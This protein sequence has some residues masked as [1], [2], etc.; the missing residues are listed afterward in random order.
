[1]KYKIGDKVKYDDGEWL[2]YGTVSA[3]YEHSICPLYRVNIE[4]KEKKNGRH[5]IVQFEFELETDHSLTGNEK[6]KRQWISTEIDY[7]KEYYTTHNIEDISK[8]LKRNIEEIEDK[9][10]LIKLGKES[11]EVSEKIEQQATEQEPKV[12]RKRKQKT[13]PETE[14]DALSQEPKEEKPK[15][16][17]GKRGVAWN[18]NLEAFRNGEK[19]NVISTWVAHNRKEY[20]NGK[21]P[22]EKFEKL[23]AANFPFDVVKKPKSI[24]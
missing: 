8:V 15:I 21:L 7:L 2:A 13:E 20:R 9:W 11:E 23:M 22:E 3:V 14:T 16:K 17:R 24:V 12:R 10:R 6:E 18:R 4:R 5:L 1:M 19:S